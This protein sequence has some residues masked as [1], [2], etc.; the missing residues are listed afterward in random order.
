MQK[1]PD[2][3]VIAVVGASSVGKSALIS[4]VVSAN[5]G[6]NQEP[7]TEGNRQRCTFDV[8]GEWCIVDFIGKMTRKGCLILY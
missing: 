3:I 2:A 1:R 4:R 7:E 8:E 6:A 5:L